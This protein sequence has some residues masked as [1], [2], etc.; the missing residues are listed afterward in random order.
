[1]KNIPV[2]LRRA[3]RD[4]QVC[5]NGGL[6]KAA[7]EHNYIPQRPKNLNYWTYA[8]PYIDREGG[9]VCREWVYATAA[10]CPADTEC[11]FLLLQAEIRP[12][13]RDLAGEP[14]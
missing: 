14:R 11:V 1:M 3:V 9:G 13:S 4:F 12:Q 5:P 7:P 6:L 2:G 8:F 10:R